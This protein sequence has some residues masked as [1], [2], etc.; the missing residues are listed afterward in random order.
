MVIN[1]NQNFGSKI[2]TL[3][4]KA[5]LLGL[6]VI[7]S[8]GAFAQTHYVAVDGNDAADRGS[9]QSP[10]ATISYAIDNVADGATILVG[11]GTYNG[12]VR[13]DQK[14][15]SGIVIRSMPL[16]QARLRHNN[17]SAVICFTC[18]G[19]TLEGF[20][21]AHSANN[22]RGLVIQIQTSEA[23]NVV[24]RNNIIHDSTN[25]DL[26]KINNGTRDILVQGNL[27]YNQAGSDEHI[28]INSVENVTIIDNVF[29]NSTSQEVTSSYVLVK[30]SNG[31]SD[32]IVGS[33][34]IKIRRN[35]FFNWQGNSGQS[36]VRIGEDNTPTFEAENVLI[37][38]NLML[39]N[40]SRMM[41]SAFTVG[42]SKN[43]RFQFNTVVGNLPSRSFTRLVRGGLANENIS[44]SNNIWSDPTGTLG[45]EGFT[46]AD[47]FEA[48]SGANSSVTLDNNVY[49]N[50]GDA[51]PTDAG[52][53]VNI[54]DDNNAKIG[55]P[56]LPSQ[57]GIVLPVYNG[58]N[59]AGGFS[60]IRQ[61]FVDLANRYGKPAQGS[62]AIDQASST[63]VPSDDLLGAPRT[64]NAD[65]GAIE[66]GA[67]A[68]TQPPKPGMGKAVMSWLILLLE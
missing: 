55:N 25:N 7:Q 31:N 35:I 22:N 6:V 8:V 14:F 54:G 9:Q 47:V 33:K 66:V 64:S 1:I 3:L 44:L 26:L 36:F 5:L 52:Q 29:F 18:Q 40:S 68:P 63:S 27:F 10:W 59:F 38:N 67:Q 4:Y 50:G 20:D 62:I 58:S 42:G 49:Y 28:D 21:I 61:V 30:D 51:I 17:G 57:A 48:L 53:E 16:Y 2:K 13:L 11:A 43:I 39:G 32:G 60:N 45:T 65:I 23:R 34:D 37:E 46:G 24:L 41:R 12:Q 15:A 19:V 56:L